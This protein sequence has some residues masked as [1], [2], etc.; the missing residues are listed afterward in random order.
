MHWPPLLFLVDLYNQALLTM[1]DDEFFS[2]SPQVVTSAALSSSASTSTSTTVAAR[3]PLTLDEIT[4]FSK[5]LLYIAFALYWR[6]DQTNVQDSN[7]PG[8]A[9]LKWETVRERITKLLQAIH[10][11]EYD[12]HHFST[13]ILFLTVFCISSRKPFTSADY[14]LVTSQLDIGPFIEAAM[15]EERKLAG[16]VPEGVASRR[17]PISQRQIALLSP[18]LGV[19]NNIPFAIPFDVRVSIFR[20][21]I[22]NDMEMSGYDDRDRYRH[23]TRVTVRRDNIAQDGFDRL[24]SVDLKGP[25]AITFIDQFGQ[26]E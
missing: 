11:R 14:W 22:Q 12:A 6:E 26:E 15:F 25:V 16:E 21:F 8:I 2:S 1:G 17:R 13:V 20:H 9:N 19:L 7:V 5:Q 4:T 3:N 24:E 18:R 23:I 10:A